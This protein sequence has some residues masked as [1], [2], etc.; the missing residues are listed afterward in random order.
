MK[1]LFESFA[2]SS[3]LHCYPKQRPEVKAPQDSPD[4]VNCWVKRKKMNLKNKLFLNHWMIS[5][6]ISA[7]NQ[8]LDQVQQTRKVWHFMKLILPLQ[9]VAFWL[10]I[11]ASNLIGPLLFLG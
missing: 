2:L 10:L 9:P 5:W 1:I 8:I 7:V 4:S 11:R 6:Q 3:V